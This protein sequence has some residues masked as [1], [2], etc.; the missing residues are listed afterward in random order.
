MRD[1]WDR[2][3]A[4]RG[5]LRNLRGGLIMEC[6]LAEMRYRGQGDSLSLRRMRKVRLT[7]HFR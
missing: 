6:W 3:R 1:W 7:L 5:I 2:G 4:S